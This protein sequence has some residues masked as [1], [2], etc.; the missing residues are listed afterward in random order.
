MAESS[1]HKD[2]GS[3]GFRV[4]TVGMA[5]IGPFSLNIFKPCLPFIKADFDAPIEVVQLGLSLGVL[6]AAVATAV[7]GPLVD[8]LGRKP[9]IL[10]TAWLYLLSSVLG[11]AAPNVEVLIVARIVQA[12]TSSV[13]MTVIR[14]VVHDVH[15]NAERV[16]AR[17]TLGAVAAVLLSPALGGLLIDQL[18]WRAVFALTAVVGVGLLIPVHF[19]LGE[20]LFTNR[21]RAPLEGTLGSQLRRLVTAPVF[22]G[23][24]VQSA[25]HF[26]IFFAFT[27][28]STYLMVDLLGRAAYEY[29]AWFVVMG[30]FVAAGL[31]TAERLSSGSKA[32]GVA[33]IGSCFV[34]VGSLASA[35]VLSS[36]T[37]ELT[38]AILSRLR[39]WFRGRTRSAKHERRRDGDR[40]G[41]RG[42]SVRPARVLSAPGRRDLRPARGPRRTS[43]RSGAGGVARGR[44]RRSVRV[45]AA[46]RPAHDDAIPLNRDAK[47]CRRQPPALPTAPQEASPGGL[48]E[49]EADDGRGGHEVR[50]LR[51]ALH[52]ESPSSKPTYK[53][54]S[55]RPTGSCVRACPE[56]S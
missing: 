54:P 13:A 19:S 30:L 15:P 21:E 56:S 49:D 12:A 55:L 5:A 20:T 38:P 37:T 35:W 6:A 45:F 32:G 17:V 26:A 51:R 34:L 10:A 24:A 42:H 31:G 27:S 1:D 44:G 7:S 46:L 25:L 9:I 22:L 16:I 43:H 23:Y 14:T 8:R 36:P 48:K 47:S 3:F 11:A 39:C 4:L 50:R 18:G 29:G 52:S 2:T 28:A 40:P 41:D 53:T 33:F